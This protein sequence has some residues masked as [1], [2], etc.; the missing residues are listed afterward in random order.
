MTAL[1]I[2]H[3]D[4]EP[5][6][7]ELVNLSLALDPAFSVR[8]CDSGRQQRSQDA[9]ARPGRQVPD[10]RWPPRTGH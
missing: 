1:R 5:D 3:V 10:K 7:R 9:G 4:D 6:I 8:S 2:L